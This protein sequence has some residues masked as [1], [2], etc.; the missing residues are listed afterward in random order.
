MK[1]IMTREERDAAR[2][3]HSSLL[4]RWA[5]DA[6]WTDVDDAL[7]GDVQ[8]ALPRALDTIDALE[9]QVETL[10]NAL[11][12]DQTGLADALAEVL[13]TVRGYD[14][15]PRGEPASYRD[16]EL[17]QGW[18]DEVGR[19]FAAIE[20]IA[21]AAYHNPQRSALLREAFAARQ[22]AEPEG[23]VPHA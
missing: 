19:C 12:A 11:N 2:R 23:E 21:S 4:A 16:E 7:N 15:I 5:P 22:L 14:W 10:T 1:T 8:R 3:S 17:P 18:L 13:S 9:Q 6:E 20:R